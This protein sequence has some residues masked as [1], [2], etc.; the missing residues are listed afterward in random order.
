MSKSE[1]VSGSTYTVE[2]EI[3]LVEASPINFEQAQQLGIEFGKSAQSVIA[4]IHSLAAMGQEVTYVPK[5]KP[6]KKEG[7]PTKATLANA[8]RETSQLRLLGLEKAGRAALV[9]LLTY[10]NGNT[11]A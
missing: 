5:A 6:A 2:Q 1:K 9:E 8:I 4:K 3:R 11:E 7:G 10:V